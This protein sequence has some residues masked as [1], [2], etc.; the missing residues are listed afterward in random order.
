MLLSGE[1]QEFVDLVAEFPLKCRVDALDQALIAGHGDSVAGVI[2]DDFDRVLRALQFGGAFV[3]ALFQF[4][5]VTPQGF[6]R[7]T[8]FLAQ[9]VFVQR[10]LDR[11]TEPH[12]AVFQ[13]IV[14]R[15]KLEAFHDHLLRHGARDD[16]Q[17]DVYPAFV[18]NT[19]CPNRAEPR[20]A[21]IGNDQVNRILKVGAKIGFGFNP[22]ILRLVTSTAKLVEQQFGVIGIVFNQQYL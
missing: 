18:Q 15:A 19:Q 4:G 21:V 20:Q 12:Q 16:D 13:Q 8:F 7:L 11:A 1:I 10:V 9:P 22:L 2:E 6:I 3:D 5:G 14:R 17:R